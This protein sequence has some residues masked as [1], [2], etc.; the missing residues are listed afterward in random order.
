MLPPL[1]L[2]S[3]K[4]TIVLTADHHGATERR[5]PDGGAPYS[6]ASRRYLAVVRQLIL[7][8]ISRSTLSCCLGAWSDEKFRTGDSRWRRRLEAKKNPCKMPSC[9]GLW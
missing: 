1:E 5:A 3:F 7:R 9:K 8:G 6:L 4:P 2:G